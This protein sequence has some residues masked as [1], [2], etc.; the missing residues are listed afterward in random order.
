MLKALFSIVAIAIACAF[1]A[2]ED[3][4][5]KVT[6]ESAFEVSEVKEIEELIDGIDLQLMRALEDDKVTL[7]QLKEHIVQ[8]RKR[9]LISKM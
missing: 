6:E 7:E 9:I 8:V 3:S 4:K 1:I 2:S 5:G